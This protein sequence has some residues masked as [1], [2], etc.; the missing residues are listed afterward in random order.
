MSNVTAADRRNGGFHHPQNILDQFGT[1]AGYNP[2]GYRGQPATP[3]G[4]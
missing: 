1:T 2:R 3:V 4:R